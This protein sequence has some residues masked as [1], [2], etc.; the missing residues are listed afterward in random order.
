MKTLQSQRDFET[1]KA[2]LVEGISLDDDCPSDPE[3][4]FDYALNRF[5]AETE[6]TISRHGILKTCEKWLSGLALHIPFWNSDI[7]DLGLDPET[8]FKDC[9]I[10]FLT[11]SMI[12]TS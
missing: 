7:E 12:K 8:Y 10:V 6:G 2:L 4:Y 9:A 1:I 3:K 5:F 11:E